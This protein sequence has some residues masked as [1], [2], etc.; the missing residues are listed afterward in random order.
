MRNAIKR[1]ITYARV[2]LNRAWTQKCRNIGT[3][4]MMPRGRCVFYNK[5]THTRSG[6]ALTHTTQSR[7]CSQ[8]DGRVGWD[9]SRILS[10]RKFQESSLICPPRR[11]ASEM[12]RWHIFRRNCAQRSAPLLFAEGESVLG[13]P[14]KL[15][16][17]FLAELL[18]IIHAE[19]L[20]GHKQRLFFMGLTVQMFALPF[21]SA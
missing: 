14:R 17:S 11:T 13:V 12:L 19:L 1:S 7:C 18:D 15:R 20:C 6:T 16:G 3:T 9:A 2:K 10:V 5:I 4:P 8:G 21:S